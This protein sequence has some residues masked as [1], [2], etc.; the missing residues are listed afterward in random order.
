MTEPKQTYDAVILNAYENEDRVSG[1]VYCDRH[2]RFLDGEFI[3]TSK[4]VERINPTI[5]R[6]KNSLYKVMWG[7]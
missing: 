5:I 1:R 4:V 2:N 7:A 6:T 3:T